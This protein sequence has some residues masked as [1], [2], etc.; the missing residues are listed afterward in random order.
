MLALRC[1][2]RA[3]ARARQLLVVATLVAGVTAAPAAMGAGAEAAMGA[4]ARTPDGMIAAVDLATGTV[5]TPLTLSTS[6]VGTFALTALTTPTS[7]AAPGDVAYVT[8]SPGGPRGGLLDEV[9]S[10]GVS[11]RVL[12]RLRLGWQPAWISVAPGGGTG[13]VAD[14]GWGAPM[15]P[16]SVEVIRLSADALERTVRVPMAW[17]GYDGIPVEA[18]VRD[19]NVDYAIDLGAGTLVPVNVRDGRLGR[20]IQITPKGSTQDLAAVAVVP[21]GQEALVTN[22][23]KGTVVAVNLARR[24]VSRPIHIGFDPVDVTVSPNGTT[25]YVTDGNSGT[26]IPIGLRS[27][28]AGRPISVGSAG[29]MAIAPDGHTGYVLDARGLA[30]VDLVQSRVLRTIPLPL[31]PDSLALGPGGT[32]AYVVGTSPY[33]HFG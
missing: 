9:G 29:Q 19:G 24:S 26:I 23:T 32:V 3:H 21:D 13:C 27:W 2:P 22:Y 33:I 18:L 20:P 1:R 6:P 5:G 11:L 12:H 4:A 15:R 8:L 16:S 31:I 30:V 7:V 28:R 14:F 17:L 25:A 10:N